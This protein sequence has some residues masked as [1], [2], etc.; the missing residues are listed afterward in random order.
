[1]VIASEA[2]IRSGN[3]PNHSALFVLHEGAEFR[4]DEETGEWMKIRLGDG[5]IGWVSASAVEVI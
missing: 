5:K 2:T 4:V 1:V 3:G